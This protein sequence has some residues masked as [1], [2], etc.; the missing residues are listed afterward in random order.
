LTPAPRHLTYHFDG[1]DEAVLSFGDEQ[2]GQVI[3]IVPPLFDEMN[4]VRAMLVGAMRELALRGIITVLPDIPGCN[5]SLA[6]ISSQ[7][8]SSWRGAMV[9]A[10][11]QLGATHVASIRGGALIDAD[12]ALLHWRLA[13]VKGASLLK[14]MLR[15]R[16]ASDKES[17]RISSMES[18]LGEAQS[19]PIELSGYMLGADMLAELDAAVPDAACQ[20]YDAALGDGL[21]GKPLWLRADP[22]EDAEMSLALAA[23]LDRWSASCG[24]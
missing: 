20:T 6:A 3:M 24:G 19:G 4:R 7:S 15:T 8:I 22:Q 23:E 21:V 1:R 9:A 18:L 5:E 14:T 12:I 17:G 10:A 13:A 16:I 11:A 2:A